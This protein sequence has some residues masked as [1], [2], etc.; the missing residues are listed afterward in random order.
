MSCLSPRALDA[1]APVLCAATLAARS[2]LER[3]DSARDT[4]RV[5]SPDF[6]FVIDECATVADGV[7]V[8]GW[9]R[10]GRVTSGAAGW[11]QERGDLAIAVR[12]IDV[13]AV[14]PLPRGRMVLV[15]RGLPVAL[16]TGGAV[17][18]SHAHI[19]DAAVVDSMSACPAATTQALPLCQAR[20][21]AVT[22]D[23]GSRPDGSR[24]TSG[25]SLG[26]PRGMSCKREPKSWQWS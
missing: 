2:R 21:T 18:R 22:R 23:E 4:G 19:S 10:C 8:A 9:L 15:L 13:E 6:E 20:S 24:P 16:V 5:A 1:V 3:A 7:K 14:A 11:L 25:T 17:L 26:Q 12:R